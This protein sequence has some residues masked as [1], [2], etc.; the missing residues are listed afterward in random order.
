MGLQGDVNQATI[1]FK[2]IACGGNCPGFKKQSPPDPLG[3]ERQ[4]S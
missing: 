4:I 2:D 3:G 1:G